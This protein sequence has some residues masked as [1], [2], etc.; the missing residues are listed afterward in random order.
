MA[1]MFIPERKRQAYLLIAFLAIGALGGVL[2]FGFVGKGS[3]GITEF[4]VP[5][6]SQELQIDFEIFQ[7]PIFQELQEP[8]PPIPFPETV[9]KENPFNKAE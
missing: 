7:H 4:F 6:P 5:P 9:G 8:G 2:W 1:F 3:P